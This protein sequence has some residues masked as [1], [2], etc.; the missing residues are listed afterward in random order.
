MN[1]IKLLSLGSL[2][3]ILLAS[4]SAMAQSTMTGMDH[5]SMSHD[6]MQMQGGSAPAD[7]RDPHAYAAGNTLASGPYKL[8]P[9]RSLF[10]GDEHHHSLFLADRLEA[11]RNDEDETSG[12]YEFLARWGGDYNRMVLKAEGE[13]AQGKLQESSTE[14][15]WSHAVTAYWDA[16]LGLRHDT[17]ED[18]KDRNW[19]A[20]GVEGL[21]PYWFE[22]GAMAYLG[23]DG[24]TALSLSVEYE[25]LLTQRLVL[26]PRLEADAYGRKDAVNGIGQGLSSVTTGLR[27]R[28]EFSRQFAPYFGVEWANRFGETADLLRAADESTHE[29]RAVAGLRFWF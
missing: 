27:L 22:V 2:T 18:G 20:L 3:T 11:V 6:D 24:R 9:Q 13:A 19:L 14:A 12:A 10:M 17:S 21:A 1:K 16:Q 8:S 25:L 29:T 28:Y 26:Q 23:Q 15:L 5:G 7:A 4:Q